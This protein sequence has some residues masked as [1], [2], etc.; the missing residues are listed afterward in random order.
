[1]F[2][3]RELTV[4]WNKKRKDM[5]TGDI[6]GEE[7]KFEKRAD[8]VLFRIEDLGA[9]MFLGVCAYILL[10]T[11]RQVKVEHARHDYK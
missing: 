3:D 1:M 10:D 9:K 4:K 11:F 2:K 6:P 5:T 8:Q 7:D